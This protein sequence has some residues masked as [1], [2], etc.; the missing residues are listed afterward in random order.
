MQ[1]MFPKT[2]TATTTPFPFL[3]L[4]VT[5]NRKCH[6]GDHLDYL[7]CY[8]H[9][10]CSECAFKTLRASAQTPNFR[11]W[12]WPWT[13]EVQFFLL[14]LLPKPLRPYPPS[15]CPFSVGHR[16]VE[17]VPLAV[18]F[19][20][21]TTS[22]MWRRKRSFVE[23]ESER[24][25]HKGPTDPLRDKIDLVKRRRRRL[26]RIYRGLAVTHIFTLLFIRKQDGRYRETVFGWLH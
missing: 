16:N 3:P 14:L 22:M 12:K 15:F 13:T 9:R 11:M 23:R 7:E 26:R 4:L 6:C 8:L 2:T 17:S 18:V 10:F 1:S 21:Q 25:N 19:F 20:F 24:A 5:G